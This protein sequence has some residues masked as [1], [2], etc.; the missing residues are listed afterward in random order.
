MK[1]FKIKN[2]KGNIVES[3]SKF[4]AMHKGMK[5]VE[6]AEIEKELKIITEEKYKKVVPILISK[7]TSNITGVVKVEFYRTIA[8]RNKPTHIFLIPVTDAARSGFDSTT[9]K[10]NYDYRISSRLKKFIEDHGISGIPDYCSVYS[11]IIPITDI[12]EYRMI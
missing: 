11:K 10:W 6:V 7:I 5:I 4:Q 9:T 12:P 2:Y 3:L 1:T 8:S